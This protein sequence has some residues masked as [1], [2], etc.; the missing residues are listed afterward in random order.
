MALSKLIRAVNDFIV[1][2]DTVKNMGAANTDKKDI[3]LECVR[4]L[5]D[6]KAHFKRSKEE[7]VKGNCTKNK[8]EFLLSK[9][10]FTIFHTLI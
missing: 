6:V 1:I 4:Q 7:S 9:C 3:I 10:I 8:A 5:G 2:H